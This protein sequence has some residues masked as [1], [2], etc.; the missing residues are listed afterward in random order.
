[1]LLAFVFCMFLFTVFQYLRCRTPNARRSK[2]FSGVAHSRAKTQMLDGMLDEK[3]RS[4]YISMHTKREVL[5]R[6]AFLC[7]GCKTDVRLLKIWDFDHK[8]EF[9]K[10]GSNGPENIQMYCVNCHGLKHRRQENYIKQI[11]TTTAF[12]TNNT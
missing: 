2:L 8:R 4:R 9:A 6:Q 5:A 12:L 10:G 11:N 7:A 3:K 1:M